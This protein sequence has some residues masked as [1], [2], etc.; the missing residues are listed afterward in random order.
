MS[1]PIDAP[2]R[3][4]PPPGPSSPAP[5][6]ASFAVLARRIASR[7]T[8]LVV[9]GVV[10]I[11]AL[12]LGREVIDWWHATPPDTQFPIAV[13]EAD[14]NAPGLPL[15]LEFGEAPLAVVRQVVAGDRAEATA[16]LVRLCRSAVESSETPLTADRSAQQALVDLT[17]GRE[18]VASE[19]GVWDVYAMEDRLGLVMGVRRIDDADGGAL[20]LIC[21]GLTM[22]VGEHATCV[23]LF[24]SQRGSAAGSAEAAELPLPPGSHR[25]LSLRDER[26][27]GLTGF[28]GSGVPSEWMDFF[29]TELPRS[30]WKN[31]DGWRG[32]GATWIATFWQS[33][34]EA[35]VELQLTGDGS[36]GLA[37]MLTLS[38]SSDPSEILN[39]REGIE[40]RP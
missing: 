11:A 7:T 2:D 37:G 35:R 28:S 16:A 13:S 12:V 40:G 18:P 38:T 36:G 30:G 1:H 15:T 33:S 23:Y 6:A 26:G 19:A 21:W 34:G 4:L 24:Q 10:L 27:G 31:R 20:R 25:N 39:H 5:A 8:D 29:D 22:P 3:A 14:W 9:I 17:Q 32:S